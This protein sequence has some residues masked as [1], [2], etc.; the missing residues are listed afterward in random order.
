MVKLVIVTGLGLTV[1]EAVLVTVPRE[2][3]MVAGVSLL[4]VPAVTVKVALVLPEATVTLVGT[5]AA[6]LSLER[7][8]GTPPV[9]AAAVRVT[10]P[11]VLPPEKTRWESRV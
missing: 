11:V 5:V 6:G 10:V 2:A 3:V 9:G 7:A 1:R 8:T 4:T